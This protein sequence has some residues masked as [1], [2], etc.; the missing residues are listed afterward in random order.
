M[1]YARRISVRR[2]S[3]ALGHSFGSLS[4]PRTN[5]N[6]R[7]ELR[8][9]SLPRRR[10][11]IGAWL[12][13]AFLTIALAPVGLPVRGASTA[14]YLDFE[15]ESASAMPGASVSLQAFVYDQ[16]GN[17]FEGPDTST[18]VRFFFSTGSPNDPASP[19]SSPDISCD[20]GT[21]GQCSVTYVAVNAGTDIICARFSGPPS[22]C[23]EPL[24]AP[25]LA[26]TAD[27]VERIVTSMP[28]PTPTPA[29]TPAPTPTPDP[30]PTPTPDPTPTPTPD[31]T[32][33]PTPEPTSTPSPTPDP[34]PTATPEPTVAPTPTPTPTATPAPTVAPTPTA[35][36]TP[37]PTPDQ[38]P[39]PTPD[40]PRVPTA[41]PA[42]DATTTAEVSQSATSP[43][44]DADPDPAQP[45]IAAV[46][47]NASPSARPNRPSSA[48]PPVSL[49]KSPGVFDA[50]I[51]R[52]ANQVSVVVRPAAAAAVASS[53]TFPLLLM[54]AV[55]L[56]L[57]IQA[58]L[59]RRDPKLRNAPRTTAETF[60]PFEDEAQL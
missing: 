6:E 60:L 59:D 20:T 36:P 54:L 42:P 30:T 38:T 35:L 21:S 53:F 37:A 48:T 3:D 40:Q 32:A 10:V 55:L 45:A 9:R 33:T 19:G 16:D 27:V 31:P 12:A 15:P 5:V 14:T 22:L 46:R 43:R 49:P 18:H 34:T 56:F 11:A 17:L 8:Q 39:V 58:R 41:A 23:D 29:P 24:D 57:A 25:E 50:L 13:G 1:A 7:I 2:R 52:V 4:L 28:A 51:S 44:R 47:P 26:N